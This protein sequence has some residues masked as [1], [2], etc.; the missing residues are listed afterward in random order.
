MVTD[1]IC[2]LNVRK[3]LAKSVVDNSN[4]SD[5]SIKEKETLIKGLSIF[6]SCPTLEERENQYR[7]E[8]RDFLK[9]N[10]LFPSFF[11]RFF[12]KKSQY[13]CIKH[14]GNW[15]RNHNVRSFSFN[16]HERPIDM[17]DDINVRECKSCGKIHFGGHGGVTLNHS[18]TKVDIIIKEC[19]KYNL[20]LDV[21]HM[22]F[23]SLLSSELKN[24]YVA[25]SDIVDGYPSPYEKKEADE[26]A[27]WNLWLKNRNL[28]ME[29]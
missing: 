19:K 29:E 25:L 3:D 15:R 1:K 2:V 28:N 18:A 16:Y 17:F 21:I 26:K 7:K 10:N 20:G 22:V 13:L 23:K 4:L 12:S 6:L 5:M 24:K 9:S 8:V 11:K 14:L 27:E